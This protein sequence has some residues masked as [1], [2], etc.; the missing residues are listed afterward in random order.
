MSSTI[1]IKTQ[2]TA[3]MSNGPKQHLQ[4]R[5]RLV[6]N[7]LI[8]PLHHHNP[9]WSN[10]ISPFQLHNL[11]PPNLQRYKAWHSACSKQVL[12]CFR[13]FHISH[14]L[15][16]LRHLEME[17]IRVD[18]ETCT[19][20]CTI[21]WVWIEIGKRT[22]SQMPPKWGLFFSGKWPLYTPFL[23]EGLKYPLSISKWQTYPW[24]GLDSE[25]LM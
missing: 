19:E 4:A 11:S 6:C 1:F 25:I 9:C 13:N 10:H 21:I 5:A 17:Q 8:R 3:E 23:A 22:N 14:I 16:L 7:H 2:L 24:S 20:M 12:P 18:T 15:I